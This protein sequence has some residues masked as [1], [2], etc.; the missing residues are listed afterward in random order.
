[1]SDE[2]SFDL[3]GLECPDVTVTVTNSSTK[4]DTDYNDVFN[5]KLKELT[6]CDDISVKKDNTVVF[7]YCADIEKSVEHIEAHIIEASA[8]LLKEILKTS[9]G[10]VF[11]I[12]ANEGLEK[13]TLE[14]A[15]FNV[16]SENWRNSGSKLAIQGAL[17]KAPEETTITF[18]MPLA[19]QAL[20]KTGRVKFINADGSEER[21]A[22]IDSSVLAGAS[23]CLGLNSSSLDGVIPRF[24]ISNLVNE[25]ML[26]SDSKIT[27]AGMSKPLT[28]DDIDEVVT[29]LLQSGEGTDLAI[30]TP[31]VG[32]DS[33]DTLED[34][35]RRANIKIQEAFTRISDYNKDETNEIKTLVLGSCIAHLIDRDTERLFYLL[36]EMASKVSFTI[37]LPN[38]P[39]DSEREASANTKSITGLSDLDVLLVGNTRL[40]PTSNLS[41][42]LR[43]SDSSSVN[44]NDDCEGAT[45]KLILDLIG[46]SY[47]K[48]SK[49]LTALKNA[50]Y[51]ASSYIL[52]IV[53]FIANRGE[54]HNSVLPMSLFT[55]LYNL[56]EAARTS[57]SIGEN[58][59]KEFIYNKNRE[60]FSI[61]ANVLDKEF[62]YSTIN[63]KNNE[64]G[65]SQVNVFNVLS[66]IV[67]IYTTIRAQTEPLN[68]LLS[69]LSYWENL[70]G[71]PNPAKGLV[72]ITGNFGTLS[73]TPETW[74]E[75]YK[76][77]LRNSWSRNEGEL[78][79]W[80]SANDEEFLLTK[81]ELEEEIRAYLLYH[82]AGLSGFLS[83]V[84]H[85]FSNESLIQ[86]GA[87]K[88]GLN[89]YFSGNG[90]LNSKS[91]PSSVNFEGALLQKIWASIYIVMAN[92]Q[93]S[94]IINKAIVSGYRV[95]STVN[96][97]TE[98]SYT[99][100]VHDEMSPYRL[101]SNKSGLVN[102][103][104][105]VANPYMSNNSPLDNIKSNPEVNFIEELDLEALVEAGRVDEALRKYSVNTTDEL[106]EVVEL[107][108]TRQLNEAFKKFV[109]Y[110]AIKE[111]LNGM[112]IFNVPD[113][114]VYESSFKNACLHIN[115][116]SILDSAA[117]GKLTTTTLN[118]LVE[119][120]FSQ[121]RG[122]N[123]IKSYILSD[124]GK[125]VLELLNRE[126]LFSFNDQMGYSY[127]RDDNYS[128]KS[129]SGLARFSNIILNGIVQEVNINGRPFR[130]TY[131]ELNR[132]DEFKS[133]L[134]DRNASANLILE[135]YNSLG[136]E[137]FADKHLNKN[138]PQSKRKKAINGLVSKAKATLNNSLQNRSLKD[139]VIEVAVQGD[140]DDITVG[141]EANNYE[142]PNAIGSSLG[143]IKALFDDFKL[144]FQSRLVVGTTKIN[145]PEL[146]KGNKS[147]GVDIS[148]LAGIFDSLA[149]L[150]QVL[151]P[152]MS[153]FPVVW[154]SKLGYRAELLNLKLN[155]AGTYSHYNLNDPEEKAQL[156]NNIKDCNTVYSVC[157]G[158]S[159]TSHY[160]N[161]LSGSWNFLMIRNPKILRP[162]ASSNQDKPRIF[163]FIEV[164]PSGS[165]NN[166]ATIYETHAEGNRVYCSNQENGKSGFEAI[167]L[168]AA[169]VLYGLKHFMYKNGQKL[170][171]YVR[172]VCSNGDDGGAY[173][174]GLLY[175]L[176][177]LCTGKVIIELEEGFLESCVNIV[178][179]S[180]NSILKNLVPEI[181]SISSR[182]FFNSIA[183]STYKDFDL[184]SQAYTE[185]IE[186]GAINSN[187]E[188]SPNDL[189]TIA[190]YI[191]RD[192]LP[193]NYL[194]SFL[195]DGDFI[196]AV[197]MI[198]KRN[199]LDRN[200]EQIF[201]FR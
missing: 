80:S 11:K 152:V 133:A 164:K 105:A 143:G 29:S 22:I 92:P 52:D 113:Q 6:E 38:E 179:S 17:K 156:E 54:D 25:E 71:R 86:L 67:P 132:N 126:N 103:L 40:D 124:D 96:G 39:C 20:S 83:S 159:Q 141:Q 194:L 100:G 137:A 198:T 24:N 154:E 109:D 21:T 104:D 90:L 55:R 180:H 44:L 131:A 49:S 172:G 76:N 158:Q 63:K 140:I 19:L 60:K 171:I 193:R 57:S 174:Y 59:L 2:I 14:G 125:S 95:G 195:L 1:M 78:P 102:L 73:L 178:N 119:G 122:L 110:D 173:T 201:S 146:S 177:Y 148:V 186:E 69:V 112:P 66:Y 153:D 42:A 27:I 116:N 120:I 101:D 167:D 182:E 144:D 31:P 43:V 3:T 114:T 58:N 93:A 28:P 53:Q 84:E 135:D 155:K 138:I 97:P 61:V 197:T 47:N 15:S 33:A 136:E 106:P 34:F 72:N 62:S 16:D 139:L 117:S 142:S 166:T 8:F 26:R 99:L 127:N 129:D 115:L 145:M 64:L 176:Y 82:D 160:K 79:T 169:S 162:Y 81:Q 46:F 185:A 30:I 157:I 41:S 50:D 36:S 7:N 9:P 111:T 192:E 88:T 94:D 168:K 12:I 163:S 118:Q 70:G 35:Y 48:K 85:L 188:L 170:D 150:N 98:V 183:K 91:I 121:L 134:N 107:N 10:G 191:D 181:N 89:S 130:G 151:N 77:K 190:S 184:L 65:L 147:R 13:L 37:E 56:L 87:L 165:N 68:I 74:R 75:E 175:L 128:M 187:G 196:E 18:K 32:I 123:V 51:L 5:N 189:G 149:R 108:S 4:N 23:I 199:S 161:A 45:A 200:K